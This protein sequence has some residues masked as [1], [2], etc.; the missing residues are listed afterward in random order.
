ME[1][2]L[3]RGLLD[4]IEASLASVP[5]LILEGPRASGKTSIG[6][7]LT[8]RGLITTTADLGDPTVLAAA[9]SAPTSFVNDLSAPAFIDE[10]Q[11]VPEIALAVKRRVD[12]ERR[13]GM[14]V[15][16]GSSRLGRTTL[17]GSDALAGRAVRMRLWP[18]T[19]AELA[20]SPVSL[21]SDLFDAAPGPAFARAEIARADL[22]HRIR[23]GGL[24]T[25]AGVVA[26]IEDAVRAQLSAEYVEGV[27]HHEIGRRQ[28]RS[29]MIRTFKY[30]AASTSRL[31]NVSTVAGELQTTRETLTSRIAALDSSF[32]VH[33][34]L[35]HRPAEHRTLTSH[36]KVHAVDVGLA[37]WASRLHADPP[38][39]EYGGLLETFVVNELVAQA[40]WSRNEITV[41]HWRDTARKTEVDAVLLDATG[42]SI[43]V[44][45]KAALDVRRDDLIGLNRY[46]ATV[47]GARRG[48][49][50]YSGGLTLQ[51]DENV[52][53]VP[54]SALWNGLQPGT[55]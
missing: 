6:T 19:Q 39:H 43:P 45:V 8:D 41:R 28:D 1:P 44:E 4:R 40:S 3:K 46:L 10:A 51:L 36:P 30:L 22:L 42:A 2:F 11:L 27:V 20:G 15:L 18:M 5:V 26:P 34:L 38:A 52:W 33:Q 31:L 48:I 23:A 32:L 25:L 21:V 13:P 37:A 54:I 7:M 29:E 49:V 47:D 24:P 9:A 17:G 55:A 14:F 53:A 12:R 16:T 35:G 50:F